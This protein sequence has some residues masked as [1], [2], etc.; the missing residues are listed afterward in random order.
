MRPVSAWPVMLLMACS[1]GAPRREPSEA[2]S[3]DVVLEQ[4]EVRTFRGS[5]VEL[6]ARAPQV[7]WFS[8]T[9]GVS[10]PQARIE[11]AR[12]GVVV[13]AG[14][15]DGTVNDGVLHGQQGV[16]LQNAAGVKAE[17]PEAWYHRDQGAQGTASG[18]SGVTVHREA[19]TLNARAFTFDI[20]EQRG[21]F[22]A[23]VTHVE[24]RP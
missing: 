12:D 13:T 21:E 7:S 18:S 15:L 8:A 6:Q 3:A 10:A 22:E 23:P 16:T 20:A 14:Q 24:G 4:V 19:S 5:Q 2:A 11:G 9:T 1:A 17:A